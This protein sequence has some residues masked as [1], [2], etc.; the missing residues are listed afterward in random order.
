MDAM[1]QPDHEKPS[2]WERICC[3]SGCCRRCKKGDEME[4]MAKVSFSA[5]EKRESF[6]DLWQFKV[7]FV[8]YANCIH[9][10]PET[11][12]MLLAL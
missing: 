12:A 8:S 7:H 11:N 9:L 2:M 1:K 3:C 4:N 5:F 6:K 10:L